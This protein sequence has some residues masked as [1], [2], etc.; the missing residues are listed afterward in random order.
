MPRTTAT[1]DGV[2]LVDKPAGL[3]SHD[4]VALARRSLGVHRIGHTGT[5]D[6]F[7]TGLLILLVG[8]ATRLA[9]FVDD[10]PKVY[11]ATMEFGRETDTDDLTGAVIREAELPD[12]S[13]VDEGI[14]ALTG[15]I[16]Q[17]PPAFSA[18]KVAGRR[19]YEAA[20]SGTP[21][22]LAPA[23]VTVHG[24]D[25]QSRSSSMLRV[26]ITCGG[27][28]YIR[29]LARDLGR[30]ANS[31]AYLSSLRRIRSG[32][33]DVG[34]ARSIEELR[35]DSVPLADPRAAIPNLPSQLLDETEVERVRHGQAIWTQ[36][37]ASIV[38]LVDR[39]G[40][41][42]AVAAR[43]GKLARPIVVMRHDV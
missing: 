27:G 19:A 6:P 43:D 22:T 41:L 39:V 8:Q 28:T 10:E 9:R 29:A 32:T 31:A 26:T 40:D 24:W 33:F 42:I 11:E 23:T 17:L 21:L 3:T 20:R 2:L 30:A 14:R 13:A 1:R 12:P 4:V 37:E 15:T 34:A 7:A 35:G 16:Q 25:V 38:A 18:K 36:L 5:L